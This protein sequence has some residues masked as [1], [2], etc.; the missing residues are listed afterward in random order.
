METE[1]R[2][3]FINVRYS[4]TEIKLIDEYVKNTNFSRS[5]YLRKLSL[6]EIKLV[7]PYRKKK[8]PEPTGD[9]FELKLLSNIA[10]NIN[11]IAKIVNQKKVVPG[12]HILKDIQNQIG[13]YL[14]TKF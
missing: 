7:L 6:N 14:D 10:N 8:N 4:E 3:K 13:K 11:Q 2:N 12:D 9:K 5:E 1:K